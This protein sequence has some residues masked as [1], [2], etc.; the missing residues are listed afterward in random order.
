M[1]GWPVWITS[2]ASSYTAPSTQ[3][4]ETLP[5]TSPPADT[6]SAAPAS[7]GAL[8]NVF[9]LNSDGSHTSTTWLRMFRHCGGIVSVDI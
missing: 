7:L 9:T 1:T 4:P 2:C 5:T 3:P 8:R 6:A